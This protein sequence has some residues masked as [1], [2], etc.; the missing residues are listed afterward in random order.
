M[1]WLMMH[2]HKQGAALIASQCTQ[3]TD[4]YRSWVPPPSPTEV[5]GHFITDFS[6]RSSKYWLTPIV[7]EVTVNAV[8]SCPSSKEHSVLFN[9]ISDFLTE[10]GWRIFYGVKMF[11]FSPPLSP[12]FEERGEERNTNEVDHSM[13]SAFITE[14]QHNKLFSPLYL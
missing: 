4:V 12:L 5:R 3:D 2:G 11:G 8:L 6:Y 7:V 14:P 13:I 9:L 1:L 10:V